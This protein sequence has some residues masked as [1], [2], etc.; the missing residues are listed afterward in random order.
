M[1]RN[2]EP[3]MA[4]D[5]RLRKWVKDPFTINSATDTCKKCEVIQ[6]DTKYM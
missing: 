4:K 5:C 3:G 2:I 1:L 6:K